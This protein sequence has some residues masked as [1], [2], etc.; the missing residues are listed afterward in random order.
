M[1]TIQK[2]KNTFSVLSLKCFLI[3]AGMGKK[4]ISGFTFFSRNLIHHYANNLTFQNF[5]FSNI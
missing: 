1:A 2:Y 5:I 4:Q 3:L